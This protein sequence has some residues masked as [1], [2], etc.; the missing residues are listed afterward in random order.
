MHSIGRCRGLH[1]LA[2]NNRFNV[3]TRDDLPLR[4]S[5]VEESSSRSNAIMYP[6][7][8]SHNYV[9]NLV[10]LKLWN[11][12]QF[13]A[14]S[15]VTLGTNTTQGQ[16]RNGEQSSRGNLRK[17]RATF[18]HAQLQSTNATNSI[19]WLAIYTHSSLNNNWCS[20]NGRHKLGMQGQNYLATEKQSDKNDAQI[21]MSPTWP[22]THLKGALRR[23]YNIGVCPW[24]PTLRR[25]TRAVKGI[26]QI[27]Q[28]MLWVHIQ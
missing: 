16:H 27:K 1:Q 17:S 14:S 8:V 6:M 5:N 28:L 13:K 2:T 25:R 7:P 3:Q 23:K 9:S 19:P 21:Q 12:E 22:V 15:E 18:G 4:P 24:A 11:I 10:P 26:D 20:Q